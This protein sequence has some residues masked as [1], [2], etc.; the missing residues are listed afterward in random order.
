[1]TLAAV[2]FPIQTLSKEVLLILL[3][4]LNYQGR[5]RLGITFQSVRIQ[6]FNIHEVLCR[7][8]L[9]QQSCLLIEYLLNQ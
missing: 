6:C 8:M 9:L 3:L 4:M 1:M 5:E 7:E 2:R